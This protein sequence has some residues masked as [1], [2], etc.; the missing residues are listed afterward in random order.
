MHGPLRGLIHQIKNKKALEQPNEQ[1][2]VRF[3]L[4]SITKSLVVTYRREN[5]FEWQPALGFHYHFINL[6][7]AVQQLIKPDYRK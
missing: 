6:S 4:H 7:P 1:A 2:T 5:S 3:T